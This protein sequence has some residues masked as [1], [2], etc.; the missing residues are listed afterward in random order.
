MGGAKCLGREK[1]ELNQRDYDSEHSSSV[2]DLAQ[3]HAVVGEIGGSV[4]D[5]MQEPYALVA[6]VRICAG[7][8]GQLAFLP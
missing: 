1:V 4:F 2:L 7:G 5:L 6:H 8:A 3:L